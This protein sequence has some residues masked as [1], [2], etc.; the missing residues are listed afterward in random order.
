MHVVMK[1]LPNLSP[2]G[3]ALRPPSPSSPSTR[4]WSCS[5]SD[6]RG[7]STKMRTVVTATSAMEWSISVH[8]RRRDRPLG[9]RQIAGYMPAAGCEIGWAARVG[10]P[11]TAKDR[12]DSRV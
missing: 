6:R 11:R 1:P 8:T 10:N 9:T 7:P 5:S 12:R 2:S 4:L 3:D